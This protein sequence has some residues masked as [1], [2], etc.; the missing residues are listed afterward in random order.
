MFM[1]WVVCKVFVLFLSLLVFF[2]ASFYIN[3]I[4]YCYHDPLTNNTK[5]SVLRQVNM[6]GPLIGSILR[7]L[8]TLLYILCYIS[9]DSSS[10]FDIC[11][12]RH[13]CIYLFFDN[14]V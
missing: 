8:D 3:A 4:C 10:L 5:Y 12:V 2:V 14:F 6:G 13:F 7:H 11:H 1:L 9:P